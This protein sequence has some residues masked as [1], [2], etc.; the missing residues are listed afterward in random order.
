[1]APAMRGRRASSSVI[2]AIGPYRR[3]GPPPPCS[4]PE[5]SF[6]WAPL[7]PKTIFWGWRP[8]P[9]PSDRSNSAAPRRIGCVGRELAHARNRTPAVSATLASSSF[10][11]SRRLADNQL[12]LDGLDD[13]FGPQRLTKLRQNHLGGDRDRRFDILIHR[14]Q[15]R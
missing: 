5:M 13:R 7:F 2:C 3:A 11:R 8:P 9:L 12:R 1:M 6:T 10:R 4:A 14:R 15:G